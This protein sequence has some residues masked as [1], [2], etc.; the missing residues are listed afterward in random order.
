MNLTEPLT[1]PVFAFTATSNGGDDIVIRL[2]DQTVD[3][4]GN[5]TSFSF[6]LEEW[7]Y[8]DGPTGNVQKLYGRN[9]LPHHRLHTYTSVE[10]RRNGASAPTKKWQ[11]RAKT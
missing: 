1:N 2:V 9:V 4:D 6:I 8:L 10:S 5:T 3:A 11:P 7:E